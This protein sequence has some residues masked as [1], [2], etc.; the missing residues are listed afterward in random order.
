MANNAISAF[1][2]SWLDLNFLADFPS[3]SSWTSCHTK[4]WREVRGDI[5]NVH[6]YLALIAPSVWGLERW[7][8]LIKIAILLGVSSN[9]LPFQFIC[10]CAPQVSLLLPII[11]RKN[12]S[13]PEAFSFVPTF[14]TFESTIAYY[15]RKLLASRYIL[16]HLH[17][18]TPSQYP[19]NFHF[20][21]RAA[22]PGIVSAVE[23]IIQVSNDLVAT[24]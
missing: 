21:L 18:S 2:S 11:I 8:E 15:N 4:C 1:H 10:F 3:K 22:W 13:Y 19:P 23:V 17:T 7:L 6:A 5:L 9:C 20:T 12:M 24:F 16:L 14:H